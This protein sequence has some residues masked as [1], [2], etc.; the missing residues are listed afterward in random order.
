MPKITNCLWFDKEAEE[1]A[2]YYISV[3]PNSK[4]NETS[5]YDEASS[6]V[7]GMPEGTV[8]VVDFDLDGHNFMGLN[9]G[10]V[11]KFNEAISFVVHCKDQAEIEHYWEKLSAVPESEQCGWCKDKFGVSWQVVPDV[12]NEMLQDPDKE[13][14]GRAMQAMLEM[15]KINIDEL[16]LAYEG[17]KA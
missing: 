17:K 2:N 8:L 9:G 16:D 5:H 7:A 11:F 14:A 15:K 12:L 3:F 13:K 6:K 4:I 1:A 10:S